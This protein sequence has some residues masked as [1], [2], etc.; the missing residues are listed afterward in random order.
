MQLVR[1]GVFMKFRLLLSGA[2][3]I[4]AFGAQ[5]LLPRTAYA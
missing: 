5:G 2:A 3:L 1:N 4:V